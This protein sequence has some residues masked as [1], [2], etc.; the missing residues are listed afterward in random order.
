MIEKFIMFNRRF[1]DEFF[2]DLM[3]KILE[4]FDS[5]GIMYDSY[6]LPWP[7]FNNNCYFHKTNNRILFHMDMIPNLDNLSRLATDNP[8]HKHVFFSTQ[9]TNQN[10]PDFKNV[11]IVHWGSDYLLQENDYRILEPVEKKI[12]NQLPY[13]ICLNRDPK[14]H[15]LLVVSYLKG[16]GLEQFGNIHINPEKLLTIDSWRSLCTQDY[17]T[18]SLDQSTINTLDRGFCLLKDSPNLVTDSTL[19]YPKYNNDNVSNFNRYLR[20]YY[21]NTLVEIV[22]ETAFTVSGL[23]LTEKFINS[24]FGM[25]IPLLVGVPGIVSYVEKLGFDMFRDIVDLKYD[26]VSDPLQRLTCAVD[27]NIRLLSDA[28][29]AKEVWSQCQNR[30]INNVNWA[31][32]CMHDRAR[33]QALNAIPKVIE[34]LQS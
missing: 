30:L 19:I 26:N 8:N 31:K 17:Q 2:F 32:H 11:R 25:N 9:L 14:L 29:F 21:T 12:T 1:N 15:R 33:Q 34:F 27:S 7:H 20:K 10:L 24:V 13:W 16:L 4:K 23:H 28:Q 22:N 5:A 18:A 6:Y 3:I